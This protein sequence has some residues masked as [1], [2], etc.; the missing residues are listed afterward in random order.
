MQCLECRNI[1]RIAQR[2]PQ[3]DRPVEAP[4]VVLVGMQAGT[5]VGRQGRV[6]NHRRRRPAGVQRQPVQQRLKS[7]AR[8]A[9]RFHGIDVGARPVLI[10]A[11]ADHPCQDL[12]RTVVDH[13]NGAVFGPLLARVGEAPVKQILHGTLKSRVKCCRRPRSGRR[14]GGDRRLDE[15]H[16]VRCRHRQFGF[17]QVE[18]FLEEPFAFCRDQFAA[19]NHQIRQAPDRGVNGLTG[20]V[21]VEAARRTDQHGQRQHFLAAQRVEIPGEVVF[22]RLTHTPAV[23]RVGYLVQVE[24]ENL[25]LGEGRLQPRGL[26]SFEPAGPDGARARM[27]NPCDLFGNRAAA[28]HGP[29]VGEIGT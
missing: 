7:R 17:F 8:L 4:A 13:E 9:R 5:D 16:K 15:T 27:Q 6:V 24:L 1:Q 21:E 28:A 3:A 19:F 26:E 10:P 29:P 25:V 11:P 23:G 14:A 2:V 12:P 18:F 20:A 22:G